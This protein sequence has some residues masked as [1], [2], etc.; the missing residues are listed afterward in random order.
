MGVQLLT[1]GPCLALRYQ[2]PYSPRARRQAARTQDRMW[3][4]APQRCKS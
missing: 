2:S 4:T 1:R 3:P